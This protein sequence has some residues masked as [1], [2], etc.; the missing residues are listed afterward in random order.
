[1]TLPLTGIRVLDLTSVIMGP[2][3]T[4]ILADLGAEVITVEEP[5]GT[6]SRVMTAGP[7]PQLSGIALNLLRNK[8]N[9]VLNLKQPASRD[10]LLALVRASDVLVTNLRPSAIARLRLG[11]DEVAAVAPRLVYCQAQGWPLDSERADDPAYDDI[12]QAAT[13]LPD[14]ALRAHGQAQFAPTILADKVCGLTI[15]YAVLAA[16]VGRASTGAG[17]HL[18][19]PMTDV[20]TSFV[21]VEHGAAAIP[22]P[23]LARAGYPRILVPTRRPQRTLD[24]WASVLP[25]S[26]DNYHD[27]FREGGREDLIGDDRVRSARNRVAY[28]GELYQIVDEIVVTKTTAHWRAFCA[29]AAIPM[30]PVA[31]LD[32]LVGG[33]PLADHPAAGAYR[34]IPQPV[35]ITPASQAPGQAPGQAAVTTV[36]RPAALPGEHTS[37]VLAELGLTAKQ[38]EV[39]RAEAREPTR[40]RRT[41]P[42]KEST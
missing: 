34:V 10:A 8:R 5:G 42:A 6:L 16:L 4:Q 15:A 38:I 20:M 12:I 7:H 33:L 14:A 2:F 21:L 31:T 25:Y 18:E 29:R 9:V 35:R 23:P 41:A 3:G 37:E 27:L 19:V 1:M 26:R 39:I 22:E 24:G 30:S 32:E 17:C 11:Y 13:G 40:Q 36:R 28:A